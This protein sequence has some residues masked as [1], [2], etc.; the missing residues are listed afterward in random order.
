MDVLRHA[1][2]LTRLPEVRPLAAQPSRWN[3]TLDQTPPLQWGRRGNEQQDQIDQPSLLRFPQCQNLHRRH[4]SLLRLPAVALIT[5]LGYEHFF[6][7][8]KSESSTASG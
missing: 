2:P 1:I 5:L 4:L 3:P 8:P 7:I 6:P